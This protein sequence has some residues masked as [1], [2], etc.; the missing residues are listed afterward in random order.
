MDGLTIGGVAKRAGVG[1]ET[2]R[3][4][5]RKGLLEEPP[6][7]ESGYRQY[8]EEAVARIRFIRRAKDLGFS[9]RE[10]DELLRLRVD[11]RTSASEVRRRAEAKIEDIELKLADLA[12]MKAA[13][14]ELTTC[15]EGREATG[16]CPILEALEGNSSLE[17]SQEPRRSPK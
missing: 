1:V 7:R 13:L 12:R 16:E 2:V 8:P 9:L 6:R 11:R 14:L 3:F 4:Y 15:C 5:E 10:V 17:V